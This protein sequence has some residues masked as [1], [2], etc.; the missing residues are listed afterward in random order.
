[1]LVDQDPAFRAAIIHDPAEVAGLRDAAAAVR[2]RQESGLAPAGA[3]VQPA[4][5][6][7]EAGPLQPVVARGVLGGY[8][9][10]LRGQVDAIERE[11]SYGIQAASGAPDPFQVERQRGLGAA[12]ESLQGE[13]AELGALNESEVIQWAGQYMADNPGRIR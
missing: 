2:Q 3:P 1:M 7:V 8:M 4:L 6:P 5:A 12:L 13:L 9:G 11:L 10:Q